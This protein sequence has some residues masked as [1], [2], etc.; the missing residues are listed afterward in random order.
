MIVLLAVKEAFSCHNIYH[1]SCEK[2]QPAQ[3]IFIWSE[4]FLAVAYK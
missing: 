1:H 2:D 3:I 4:I